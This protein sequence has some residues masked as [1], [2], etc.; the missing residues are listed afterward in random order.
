VKVGD[1]VLGGSAAA[2]ALVTRASEGSCRGVGEQLLQRL[3]EEQREV[4]ARLMEEAFRG[5]VFQT[6]AALYR[7]ELAPFDKGYEGAPYNDVVGRLDGWE[8]PESRHRE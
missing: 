1:I 3:S 2:Q 5:G 6:L 4:V 7:A 8:W